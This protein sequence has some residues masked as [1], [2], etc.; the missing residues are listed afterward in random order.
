MFSFSG[1]GVHV[2]RVTHE[3]REQQLINRF[4]FLFKNYSNYSK[5]TLK[6]FIL[7]LMF[8]FHFNIQFHKI[9]LIL[10]KDSMLF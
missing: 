7:L 5:I 1:E 4:D 3:S 9:I 6:Y 10:Y 8:M 2:E